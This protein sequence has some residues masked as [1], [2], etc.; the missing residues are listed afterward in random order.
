[1]VRRSQS[2]AGPHVCGVSDTAYAFFWNYQSVEF[3]NQ[4]EW[5]GEDHAWTIGLLG[6][7]R[8]AIQCRDDVD[9]AEACSCKSRMVMG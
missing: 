4:W 8:V 6:F 3:T 7:Y 1:M 9:T 2:R 5:P